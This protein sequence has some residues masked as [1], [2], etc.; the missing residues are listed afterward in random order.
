MK[1]IKPPPFH[2][3]TVKAQGGRF[4]ELVTQAEVFT[5]Q[6]SV[7][8]FRIPPD[9]IQIDYVARAEEIQKKQLRRE[10]NKL[11]KKRR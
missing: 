8:Y 6:S 2:A 7:R 11:K 1:L 9:G 3:F 4:R 5:A 10:K